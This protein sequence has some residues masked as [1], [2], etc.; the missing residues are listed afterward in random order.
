MKL[1]LFQKA[2]PN[3]SQASDRMKEC[4]QSIFSRPFVFVW[5]LSVFF[6]FQS[7]HLFSSP[8]FRSGFFKGVAFTG[9]WSGAY[10]PPEAFE[11]LRQLK[12]TGAAWVSILTTWYQND[13][14]STNI[15]FSP[16]LTPTDESLVRLIN[17]AHDLGLK[18]MLKPHIDLLYDP[19]HYRGHIGRNFTSGQWQEWFN[20]YRSFI[21]RY[22]ALASQTRCEMFCVGCELGI[23]V[24]RSSEWR[25]I[26]NEIRTVY[27]G[28]LV[29]A[30]NL[31]ETNPDAVNWWD[32]VDFIGQDVYPTLSRKSNPSVKDLSNGWL[33][34]LDRLRRLSQKWNRPVI[35]TEIGCRSVVNGSINPWDWQKPGPPDLDIQRK[36]YEAA[37]KA[38]NQRRWLTGMF[39]WQWMPDPDHGGPSDNGYSP[40]GKPAEFVLRV[41]YRYRL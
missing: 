27:K 34:I 39:W 35:I 21:L 3:K 36:F 24:A 7:S 1:K 6:L 20:A 32:A 23:T 30:D 2:K 9:Y 38:M 25:S 5:M 10:N 40:R 41:W 19:E 28:P 17:Y 8:L 22:A 33:W 4:R 29:Y 15:F 37:F 11:S 18:I 31:I 26:I 14:N 16:D 12:N 13:I